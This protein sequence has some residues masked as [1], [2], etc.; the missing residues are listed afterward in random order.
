MCPVSQDS[1]HHFD[2][3][4]H[5]Q[6]FALAVDQ[7]DQGAAGLNAGLPFFDRDHHRSLF[8]SDFGLDK[9]VAAGVR[10]NLFNRV[11]EELEGLLALAA[12]E[13]R[14]FGAQKDALF[15]DVVVHAGLPDPEFGHQG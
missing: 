1:K 7:F 9:D 11:V 15:F 5:S 6:K 10:D 14:G 3:R 13:V 4:V 2:R 8:P 12:G